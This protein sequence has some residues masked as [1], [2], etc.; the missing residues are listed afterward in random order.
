MSRTLIVSYSRTGATHRLAEKIA[1]ATGGILEIITEARDREGFFDYMRSG[2]EA[3][4]K[5]PVPIRPIVHN[6]VDF[7]LVVLGSPVWA[8]HVSSPMLQYVR[9]C[10]Q[11]FS[12]VAF[13]AKQLS[14]SADEMFR[15]LSA[16]IG[17]A[18]IATLALLQHDVDAGCCADDISRFVSRLGL[19]SLA[20]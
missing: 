11:S 9:Q 12:A 5:Q 20:A 7:D 10:R 19:S 15:Q 18:P 17:Q 14:A 16:E 1:H 6:P 8:G 3:L 4:F 13:F 2:K